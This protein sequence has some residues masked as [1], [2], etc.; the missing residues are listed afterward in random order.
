MHINYAYKLQDNQLE[1]V[2]KSIV[3]YRFLVLCTI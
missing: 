2:L 1:K 3:C